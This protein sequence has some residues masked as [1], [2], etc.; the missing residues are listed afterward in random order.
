MLGT[1]QLLNVKSF[2]QRCPEHYDA[3]I[4]C[5]AFVDWRRLKKSEPAVLV[6]SFWNWS[7]FGGA[8]SK[9]T[10]P[11]AAATAS[12]TRPG[13]RKGTTEGRALFR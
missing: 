7:C 5:A 4:E 11:E 3:V 13:M 6:L 10:F 1:R 9:L 12:G 2:R 8:V